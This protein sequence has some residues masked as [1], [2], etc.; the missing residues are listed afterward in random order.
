VPYEGAGH[1]IG[2]TQAADIRTK[3]HKFI[4]D[5]VLP[6]HYYKKVA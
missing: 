6:L 3:A 5:E 2:V 4:A 1:E